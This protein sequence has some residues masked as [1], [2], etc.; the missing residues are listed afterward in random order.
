MQ[1]KSL[2]CL[3]VLP[4]IWGGY[5]VASNLAVAEMS[6]FTT[7]IVIRFFTMLLL[8]AMMLA[9]HQFYELFRIRRVWKKLILV[10][11]FGFLLD[12]A[13]FLGLSMCPAGIGTVL[14]KTDVIFVNL[15][16]VLIYKQKFRVRE[17]VLTFV[18]LLGIVLVL[19]L[20]YANAK[21][22]GAGNI[23][24]ILS[25][26]FVSVNAFIIKSAQHD[27]YNPASDNVVA[28]YN[29]FVTLILFTA[30]AAAAGQ[31]DQL[32]KFGREP[33]LT[34]ALLT[35]SV[36]QTFIYIFYYYNLRRF[37]VWIVKVF[38][39]LVPVVAA[40]ISWVLFGDSLSF[41]QISGMVIVLCCAG[42]I[43][44]GQRCIS[45]GKGKLP[46]EKED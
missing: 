27:R 29:N 41:I 24:F 28:F 31:L 35:A 20:D 2:V 38:L 42:G 37:P 46:A 5:Y 12:A 32:L 30:A 34:A 9:R 19:D 7:G 26:L 23:F 36:G 13:A 40:I 14:L 21:I 10:G 17:W 11:V 18:M 22:G 44:A 45:F 25:A 39:L 15:I 4:V 1:K 3:L 16:S 43:A 6:I 8:T 33:L